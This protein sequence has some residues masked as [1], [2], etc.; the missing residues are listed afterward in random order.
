MPRLN[1]TIPSLGMIAFSLLGCASQPSTDGD[2]Q[3]LMALA[4]QVQQGGDPASAAALY[5]RA[6]DASEQAPDVMIALGNARLRAG[7]SAG[8][9]EAFRVA[10]RKRENDPNALL[11][12]GTA[13][14]GYGQYDR[15]ARTLEAAAV[16]IDT[17]QVYNRLGTAQAL[18]GN[19]ESALTAYAQASRHEPGN[20]DIRSN[21]ALTLALAGRH[22]EA[23]KE[24]TAVAASPLAETHH[25][26]QL[27]LVYLLAGDMPNARQALSGLAT[28]DRERLLRDA[29]RIGTLS[30]PAQRAQAIG[31]LSTR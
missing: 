12:L 28:A 5:E 25:A 15:A 11:G 21:H 10:L 16:P 1:C 18:A 13:E 7:D 22:A 30:D 20:L 27:M 4:A 19:F 2:Q 26:K 31:V 9:T 29:S 3:R 8:A 17:A 24:M 23:V 14:L 6:A